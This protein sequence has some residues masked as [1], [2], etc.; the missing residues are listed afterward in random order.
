MFTD[1][2]TD[3][4]FNLMLRYIAA[5]LRPRLPFYAEADMTLQWDAR[6]WVELA[7]S[8]HNLLHRSHAEFFSGQANL[9][10][11][12]RSLFVTLTLRAR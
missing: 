6:P 12:D 8:G 10:E 7:L 1:I 11:Y 9:E 2:R 3:L 4:S 5:L